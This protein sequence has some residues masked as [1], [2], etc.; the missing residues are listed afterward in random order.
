[1]VSRNGHEFSSF[2]SLALS[3]AKISNEGGVILDGEITCMDAKGRP[4]FNDLLFRRREPHF[5]AFDLLCLNGNDCRRY[6][7]SQRKLAL[8]QLLNSGRR[9]AAIYVDHVEADGTGLYSRICELDLEGIVA[10]H[11]DSPHLSENTIVEA[12]ET[13]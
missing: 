13:D 12:G 4:R 11:K 5:F 8:R 3:L 2:G 10:K 6:S 9:S 1:L 7:L